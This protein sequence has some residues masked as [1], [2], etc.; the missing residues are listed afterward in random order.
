MK[1]IM[2]IGQTGCGKTTLTQALRGQ[3]ISY[4]KTQAVKYCGIVVDTPGEFVENR[5]FYS[6]LMTSA[7]KADII[8]LVQDAT[9]KTSIFPPKFAA[10][11]RKKVIGIISK[12]DLSEGDAERSERFLKRAGATAVLT[13]SATDK[14]GIPELMALLAD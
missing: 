9:R 10:M 12:A 14:T 7:L 1:K 4:V 11:F 3:E 6:A 8:G 5:R 2:F 13:T